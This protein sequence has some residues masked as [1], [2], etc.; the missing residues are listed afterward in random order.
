M[1]FALE[2]YSKYSLCVN[3]E[4][5]K[6][7]N[8]LIEIKNTI[9]QCISNMPFNLSRVK[10][11]LNIIRKLVSLVL[12]NWYTWI[13]LSLFILFGTTV[14][15]LSQGATISTKLQVGQKA[16][17][18][19]I[20]IFPARFEFIVC[21]PRDCGFEYGDC[22][23]TE[24]GKGFLCKELAP[25]ILIRVDINNSISELYEVTTAH[26]HTGDQT[27]HSVTKFVEDDNPYLFHFF[28]KNIYLEKVKNKIEFTIVDVEN[29][30]EGKE[31]EI[32]I[33]GAIPFKFYPEGYY[34]F[35]W[36]FHF[37]WFYVILLV[38]Y[39]SILLYRKIKK[40]STTKTITEIK[41]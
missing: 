13:I 28:E 6:L 23:R 27:C 15:L 12:I 5:T 20:R 31:I 14:Y 25:G 21:V 17:V 29:K 34:R 33:H 30:L 8:H 38:I 10:E 40:K 11:A 2:F 26:G 16:T 39:T 32:I 36:W 19:L 4:L 1:N 41:K 22:K 9:I 24:S 7:L 18:S 35:F 37:W 3:L